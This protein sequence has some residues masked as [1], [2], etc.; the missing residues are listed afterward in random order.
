MDAKGDKRIVKMWITNFYMNGWLSKIR[1]VQ[2]YVMTRTVYFDWIC[3]L[4]TTW[5]SVVNTEQFYKNLT[6]KWRNMHV[7]NWQELLEKNF[8]KISRRGVIIIVSSL[9]FTIFS[10][11]KRGLTSDLTVVGL[12]TCLFLLMEAHNNCWRN[13]VFTC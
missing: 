10:T 3:T 1:S 6:S 12:W 9:V 13:E 11:D 7:N 8:G 5:F 2:T 4:A